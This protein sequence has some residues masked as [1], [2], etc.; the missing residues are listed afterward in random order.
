MVLLVKIQ[1]ASI[2]ENLKKRFLDDLIYVSSPRSL[3]Y[4]M[5]L[6]LSLTHT[7]THTLLFSV[8][9]VLTDVI[10]VVLSYSGC[11][12]VRVYQMLPTSCTFG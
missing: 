4:V 5:A 11:I 3:H 7:H 6:S 9:S 1:E 8:L 12:R 10:C 2:V